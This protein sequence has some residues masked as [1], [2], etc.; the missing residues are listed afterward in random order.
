MK[1]PFVCQKC[2]KCCTLI[3][4]EYHIC[5]TEADVARWVAEERQD[6]LRWVDPVAFTDA[7]V[8][9]VFFPVDPDT[10]QEIAGPCPFLTPMPGTT[11]RICAIHETRP[12]CCR[13]FPHSREEAARIHC[14]AVERVENG[15]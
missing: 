5:L 6:I 15:E 11:S 14:P 7:P 12:Q 13:D 8:M 1:E 4:I 9:F 3:G 10:G 2:G